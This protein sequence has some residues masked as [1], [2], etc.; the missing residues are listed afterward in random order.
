MAS[1]FRLVAAGEPISLLVLA[2]AAGVDL[3]DDLEAFASGVAFRSQLARADLLC[4][5]A[6]LLAD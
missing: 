4:R 6:P 1:D 2:T 3:L 5:L